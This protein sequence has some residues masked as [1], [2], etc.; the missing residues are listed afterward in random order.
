MFF[1]TYDFRSFGSIGK[2]SSFNF[3]EKKSFA[4]MDLLG[5]NT[6]GIKVKK[7]REVWHILQR[8]KQDNV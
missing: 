2:K 6:E 7:Y 1:P 3:F 5:Q 8:V 4:K